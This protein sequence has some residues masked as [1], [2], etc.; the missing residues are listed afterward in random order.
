MLINLIPFRQSRWP[1]PKLA[2]LSRFFPFVYAEKHT[3]SFLPNPAFLI[4]AS[5]FLSMRN[6]SYPVPI[7]TR[8][9]IVPK[10]M[11]QKLE[12]KIAKHVNPCVY[13]CVYVRG[14]RV[15]IE[16]AFRSRCLLQKENSELA[17]PQHRCNMASG[18]SNCQCVW[19]F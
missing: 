12:I 1:E 11:N 7:R 8:I 10:T 9:P 5:A 4:T 18:Q 16:L 19:A 15:S 6:T 13:M 3:K 14:N 2:V 17:W